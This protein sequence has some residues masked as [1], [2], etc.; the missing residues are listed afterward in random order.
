M[1]NARALFFFGVL[2]VAALLCRTQTSWAVAITL[3]L[4][5]LV[6]TGIWHVRIEAAR[7]AARRGI[8]V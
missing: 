3:L 8:P 2:A 5:G 4:L 6:V 1:G 7:N